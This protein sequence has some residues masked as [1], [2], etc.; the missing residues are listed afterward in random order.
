MDHSIFISNMSP[1]YVSNMS[2]GHCPGEISNPC[3]AIYWVRCRGSIIFRKKT[4][5]YFLGV[6]IDGDYENK[7]QVHEIRE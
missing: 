5:E 2:S 7:M 6:M 3:G 4:A 1:V